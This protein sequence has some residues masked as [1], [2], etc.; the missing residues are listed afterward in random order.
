MV[1]SCTAPAHT[2]SAVVEAREKKRNENAVKN[3]IKGIKYLADRGEG[4]REEQYVRV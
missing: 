1:S 4:E 2:Q 3:T